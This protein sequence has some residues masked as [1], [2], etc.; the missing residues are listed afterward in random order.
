VQTA[1]YATTIV[2]YSDRKRD[3]GKVESHVASAIQAHAA[4]KFLENVVP[5]ASI[6]SMRSK[7][8]PFAPGNADHFT[9]S[10]KF[11]AASEERG[12]S[13]L[14]QHLKAHNEARLSDLLLPQESAR[15]AFPTVNRSGNS[16]SPES[17][18]PLIGF[19]R[20]KISRYITNGLKVLERLINA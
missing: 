1:Q 18:Q 19:T 6:S 20:L 5:A 2:H 10:E 11:F 17:V 13:Q 7:A 14:P 16:L 3:L 4:P 12:H 8:D 15:P 9:S